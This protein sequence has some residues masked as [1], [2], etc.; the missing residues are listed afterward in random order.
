MGSQIDTTRVNG[1]G[2]LSE[3]GEAFAGLLDEFAEP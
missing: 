2:P 1:I 3:H